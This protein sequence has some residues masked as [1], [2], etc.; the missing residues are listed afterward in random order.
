M[1]VGRK[2]ELNYLRDAIN[3]DNSNFIAIYGRRRIGKTF[4]VNEAFN[5]KFTF[6]TAGLAPNKE[7]PKS[8]NK[9]AQ[10]KHFIENLKNMEWILM[11][12]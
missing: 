6:K 12:K 9:V 11:R 4:L 1:I 5:N 7:N 10:I 3:D 8:S 2:E